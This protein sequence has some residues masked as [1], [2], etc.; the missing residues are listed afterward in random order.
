MN[1]RRFDDVVLAMEMLEL[2]VGLHRFHFYL[3][4]GMS[5]MVVGLVHFVIQ[6][7]RQQFDNTDEI[8]VEMHEQLDQQFVSIVLIH[9]EIFKRKI[10]LIDDKPVLCKPGISVR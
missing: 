2:L 4:D 6:L 1:Q 3:A 10:K 7:L 9:I 5:L 8:R